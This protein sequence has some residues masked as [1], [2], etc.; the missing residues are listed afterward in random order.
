LVQRTLGEGF[1]RLFAYEDS[2]LLLN[3]EKSTTKVLCISYA[4]CVSPCAE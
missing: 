1:K 4:H 2:F 3:R